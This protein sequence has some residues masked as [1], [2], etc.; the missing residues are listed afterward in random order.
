MESIMT[1]SPT[2]IAAIA[3]VGLMG[4]SATANA[5]PA[6]GAL[7]GA[8][9]LLTSEA[10]AHSATEAVRWSCWWGRYGRQCAWVRPR[11]YSYYY[12]PRPFYGFSFNYGYGHRRHW[13]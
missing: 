10:K 9:D 11:V 6:A 8:G 7:T 5:A 1:T 3:A 13:R 2:L 4:L 12:A